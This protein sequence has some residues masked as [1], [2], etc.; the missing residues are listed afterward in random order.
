MPAVSVSDRRILL[1]LLAF[2]A[3]A[4]ILS[5]ELV[6]VPWLGGA[7]PMV[8]VNVAPLPPGSGITFSWGTAKLATDLGLQGMTVTEVK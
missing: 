1:T 4:G 8:F 3:E 7:E 5:R 6:G 2:G